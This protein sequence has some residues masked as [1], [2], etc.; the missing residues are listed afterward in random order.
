[1]DD[2]LFSAAAAS[3]YNPAIGNTQYS[4]IAAHLRQITIKVD[5]LVAHLPAPPVVCYSID[6]LGPI[7]FSRFNRTVPREG[8]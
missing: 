5:K 4:N 1:V 2:A 7:E 6:P 8:E 3:A